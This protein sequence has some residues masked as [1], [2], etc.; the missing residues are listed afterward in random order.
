VVV[1][2]GV[3]P[4][5]FTGALL[6]AYDLT[7]GHAYLVRVPDGASLIASTIES[8]VKFEQAT[9]Q[10][11]VPVGRKTNDVQLLVRT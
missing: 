8:P 2:R 9:Q 7:L 6:N 10:F 4:D 3:L 5:P 1:S 11:V